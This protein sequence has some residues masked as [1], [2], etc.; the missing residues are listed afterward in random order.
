MRQ[1]SALLPVM[2][3]LVLLV[4]L[5]LG[6]VA[7]DD[8]ELQRLRQRVRELEELVSSSGAGTCAAQKPLTTSASSGHQQPAAEVDGAV[9][10]MYEAHPYPPRSPE[11]DAISMISVGS[12]DVPTLSAQFFGGRLL[13][14]HAPPHA[15]LR[16]L[17]AGCGTGDAV[18]SLVRS[19]DMWA[20]GSK[21]VAVERSRASLAIARQ[22]VEALRNAGYVGVNVT[23]VHGSL[24]D[25]SSLSVGHFDVVECSGVLHHLQDPVAGLVSL[26]G[27]LKPGGVI[28]LMVYAAYGRSGVYMAQFAMRLILG[29][30]T[31]AAA[32]AGDG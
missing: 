31:T 5:T 28:V 1:P 32:A 30:A 6:S 23:L 19:L 17:V 21:V 26:E 24:L 3:A 9:K 25:L 16:V 7:A 2:L 13:A 11:I 20:P 4:V 8:L 18:V 29:G 12:L 27:A 14:R 10:A 22:R 15:P